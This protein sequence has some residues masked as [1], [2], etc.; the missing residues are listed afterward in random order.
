MSGSNNFNPFDL[1]QTE[2]KTQSD[3]AERA[4]E[5]SKK[6]YDE[7]RERFIQDEISEKK[8]RIKQKMINKESEK[9]IKQFITWEFNCINT[10]KKNKKIRRSGMTGKIIGTD[11]VRY[12]N[13]PSFRE[14]E[15]IY[16]EIKSSLPRE[17]NAEEKWQADFAKKQEEWRAQQEVDAYYDSCD[18]EIYGDQFADYEEE[19]AKQKD[20]DA[21]WENE[22]EERCR[23]ADDK[24]KCH[25]RKAEIKQLHEDDIGLKGICDTTRKA[26]IRDRMRAK[27]GKERVTGINQGNMTK[28]EAQKVIPTLKLGDDIEEVPQDKEKLK[29]GQGGEEEEEKVTKYRVIENS[30]STLHSDWKV[31]WKKEDFSRVKYYNPTFKLEIFDKPIKGKD[32]FSNDYIRK[33]LK[34]AYNEV[35]DER[36]IIV[37]D[38]VMENGMVNI[39]EK[40][41]DNTAMG[42]NVFGQTQDKDPYAITMGWDDSKGNDR[43]YYKYN[44][45]FT[46]K[47][48]TYEPPMHLLSSF[49]YDITRTHGNYTNEKVSAAGP[50]KANGGK[51]KTQKKKQPKQKRAGS[52][53]KTKKAKKGGKTSQKKGKQQ[54]QKRGTRGKK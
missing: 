46:K 3:I 5:L 39:Y 47:I 8:G 37:W 24:K 11:N 49:S 41:V 19:Q 4:H 40:L 26:Q 33:N 42:E 17:L 6:G 32:Q 51:R 14:V 50:K 13:P 34:D 25:D 30:A 38:P 15:E 22:Y 53:K 12:D 2:G 9:S 1:R 54:K 29:E 20:Q 35:K 31:I 7:Q 43:P 27:S 36:K 44:Q 18:S 52:T 45:G 16:Q 21:I 23:I 10:Y 28:E 48:V